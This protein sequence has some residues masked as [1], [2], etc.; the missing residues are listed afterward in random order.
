MSITLEA[1]DDLGLEI[2]KQKYYNANKVNAKIEEL[3][4]AVSELLEENTKLKA[5]LE[6]SKKAAAAELKAQQA[7]DAK[8]KEAQRKAD[9][10]IK[11]ANEKA[12]SIVG[13]AKPAPETVSV[14]LS[15]KQL[16]LIDELNRQ[17]D[18]LSTSQTTQIFRI[19]QQLMSI[20]I[21]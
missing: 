2:V 19:K 21:D 14:G 4:T 7:A 5:Q 12:R 13:S 18:S 6:S 9:A 8:L 16:D 3:R 17:L 1:F 15:E 11:E 10:I 20:A